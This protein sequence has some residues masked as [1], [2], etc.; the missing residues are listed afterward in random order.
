MSLPYIS[1]PVTISY[2]N[3]DVMLI[4]LLADLDGALRARVLAGHAAYAFLGFGN[5]RLL[6]LEH[7]NIDRANVHACP[8]AR[9]FLLVNCRLWHKYHTP[10]N[11]SITNAIPDKSLS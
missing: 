6:G 2:Y 10:P 9:A 11:I 4:S 8:A 1:Y 5:V 3:T 7:E